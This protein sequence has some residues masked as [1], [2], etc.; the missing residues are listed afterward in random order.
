[1]VQVIDPESLKTTIIP[2]IRVGQL[3][4]PEPSPLSAGNT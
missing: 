1:M 4:T 2:L 3:G